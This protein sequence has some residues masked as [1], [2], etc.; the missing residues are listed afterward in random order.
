[1]YISG[2]L[3]LSS[4]KVRSLSI[5]HLINALLL[6]LLLLVVQCIPL[7]IFSFFQKY[8]QSYIV[9]SASGSSSLTALVSFHSAPIFA[10]VTNLQSSLAGM[11]VHLFSYSRQYSISLQLTFT[12]CIIFLLVILSF[13]RLSALSF[14]LSLLL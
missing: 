13:A 11:S 10:F 14:H 4:S 3:L 1:M 12:A 5:I 6:E 9:I 2:F 8:V 7:V